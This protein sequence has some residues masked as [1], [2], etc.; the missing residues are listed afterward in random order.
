MNQRN[1]I[2][3]TVVCATLALYELVHLTEPAAPIVSLSSLNHSLVINVAHSLE[4]RK[5][6][7]I[8]TTFT[9]SKIQGS[10]YLFTEI[11]S[12]RT[13]SFE[14]RCSRVTGAGSDGSCRRRGEGGSLTELVVV[15]YGGHDG[16]A[17]RG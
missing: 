1:A 14:E 16:A 4:Q 5:C 12:H 3:V 2:K 8:L 7:V 15:L 11:G 13:T 6:S 9:D 17:L 10:R